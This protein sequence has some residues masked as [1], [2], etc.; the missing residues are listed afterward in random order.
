MLEAV[1]QTSIQTSAI[2][3]GIKTLMM[4]HKKKIRAELPKI[5][6]Q[7]LINNLFKHPYTKIDFL[8]KEL[9]V[10]RK[11]AAKYLH[12]LCEAGFL[13]EVKL[14]KEIYF[15]NDELFQLLSNVSSLKVE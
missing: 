7:D 6:S 8:V 1:E 5:Y 11:T 14:G 3:R 10:T 9:Q 12:A 13:S 2:V 4:Q 15:L